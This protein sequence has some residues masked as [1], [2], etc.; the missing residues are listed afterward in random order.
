MHASPAG[1]PMKPYLLRFFLG[2]LLG[3]GVLIAISFLLPA[4]K[5]SGGSVVTLI[6]GGIFATQTFLRDHRR[7]PSRGEKR[8]LLWGSFAIAMV[9]QALALLLLPDPLGA[10]FWVI[11]MAI[12]ALLTLGILT[13]TYSDWYTGILLRGMHKAEARKKAR[14]Q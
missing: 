14:A 8:T 1:V 5:S 7:L 12:A 11:G 6:C 9:A 3:A 2:F 10:G 13:F 4:L